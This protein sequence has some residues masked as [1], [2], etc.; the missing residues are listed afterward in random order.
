MRGRVDS[1][2]RTRIFSE[3]LARQFQR[4]NGLLA[5]HRRE[6]LQ[7]YFESVASF[8]ILEKDP[9]GHARSHEH[10][11]SAQDFRVAVHDQF[12]AER[13]HRRSVRIARPGSPINRLETA[14]CAR[15]VNLEIPVRGQDL[16]HSGLLCHP[17]KRRVRE[18][19]RPVEVFSGEFA[20]PGHPVTHV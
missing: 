5:R 3:A 15:A 6:L 9:C 7:K 20:D 12:F 14:Q 10:G 8:K 16:Q 11:G 17:N 13:G 4:C 1:S 19:H 18:I 2:G